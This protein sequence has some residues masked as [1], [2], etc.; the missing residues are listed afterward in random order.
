LKTAAEPHVSV[1]GSLANTTR[2]GIEL[3]R[4]ILVADILVADRDADELDARIIVTASNVGSI[5]AG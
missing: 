4:D 2:F 1:V 5:T 3:E